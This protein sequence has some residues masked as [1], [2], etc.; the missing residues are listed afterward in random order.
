MYELQN[1]IPIPAVER[2]SSKAYPWS[3]MQV[4]QSFLAAKNAKHASMVS[5]CHNA[6][7]Y[8]DKKFICKTTEEGMRVWRV[9]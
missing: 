1:D 4:G 3:E 6:G 5:Q 2:K 9:A 8:R 7:K